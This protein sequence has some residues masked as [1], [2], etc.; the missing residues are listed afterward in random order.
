MSN[1]LTPISSTNIALAKTNSALTIANKLT[2]NQN[3][4]LVKEIFLKNPSFFIEYISLYYPLSEEALD[5]YSEKLERRQWHL[6]S[7]N[8]SLP[9]SENL[10]ER[11][12]D[13]WYW[14]DNLIRGL[15]K[16]EALPWSES[17]IEKFEDKWD[18]RSLSFNNS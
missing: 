14:G 4:K 5:R 10:I 11:F 7:Q 17:F 6:L 18:W 16:S 15:S 1:K 3:R 13:K 9:W 8:E 2:F 12:K